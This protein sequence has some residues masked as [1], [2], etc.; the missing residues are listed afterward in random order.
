MLGNWCTNMTCCRLCRAPATSPRPCWPPPCASCAWPSA[1]PQGTRRWW[2]R[3]AV[4]ATGLMPIW[5]RRP[6]RAV[7]LQRRPPPAGA[8]GTASPSS[9]RCDCRPT[10]A[11]WRRTGPSG[12]GNWNV[13]WTWSSAASAIRLCRYWAAACSTCRQAARPRC[14]APGCCASAWTWHKRKPCWT[15]ASRKPPALHSAALS[16]GC[17][18]SWRHSN[19]CKAISAPPCRP[20][21]VPWG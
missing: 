20:A 8:M 4:P 2:S 7:R 21:T 14:S 18:W 17:G 15:R 9:Q 11:T 19:N 6:L 12:K 5:C 16:P 10:P 13:R 1:T 3:C